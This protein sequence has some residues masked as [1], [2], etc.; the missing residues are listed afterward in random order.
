MV[1]KKMTDSDSFSIKDYIKIGFGI[2]VG[3]NLASMIY[4]FI[5][6]LFFFPGLYLLSKE[7]KKTKEE[8][9][10]TNMIIAYVL[11]ALGALFGL[12]LGF[13]FIASGFIED[14]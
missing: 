12:G 11:M 3:S 13:N 7:R 10:K 6:M 14:F 4:I 9:N 1:A 5:G 8:Q 2:G